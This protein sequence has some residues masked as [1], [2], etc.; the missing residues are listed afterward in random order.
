LSS[1]DVLDELHIRTGGGPDACIDAVGMA[2]HGTTADAIKTSLYL[3]RD[4]PNVLR[5]TIQACRKG[6]TVSIPGGMA[7]CLG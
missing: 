3:S 2:A 6:G 1:S 7:G 5:P 4:R